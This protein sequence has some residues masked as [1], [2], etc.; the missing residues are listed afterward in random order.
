MGG[1]G[2]NWVGKAPFTG[3]RHIFQNLGEGTY[4]HSGYMAIRQAIA[5][6]VNITYKILFNDAVAMTGGQPVDGVISVPAIASQV[7]A[8]GIRRGSLPC[9]DKI[10][11]EAGLLFYPY[12]MTEENSVWEVGLDWALSK[13]GADYR[14]RE[15]AMALKGKEKVKV[16]GLVADHDDAL[17]G[18]ET[19]LMNGQEVGVVNSPVYSHRMGKS[20]SLIHVT[21]EAA[22][23][24]TKLQVKGNISCGAT[25]ASIPFYDPEKTRTHG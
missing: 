3:N 2:V 18:E 16:M 8:E 22:K 4:F 5:A 20:L 11:V 23:P 24:G 9:L 12:D 21:P 14:G 10:R 17:E 19:L 25:V 13:K 7:H 1:E 15:A 6:N